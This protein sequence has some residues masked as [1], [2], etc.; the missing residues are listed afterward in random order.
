[1]I[2]ESLIMLVINAF[3]Q[4]GKGKSRMS[5]KVDQ[6][7]VQFLLEADVVKEEREERE[8]E[9]EEDSMRRTIYAILSLVSYF[10]SSS[11]NG[12]FGFRER[13]S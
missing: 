10:C 5:K 9:E 4:R 2:Y 12:V 7:S 8:E 3:Q 6:K 1:M 13:R 11:L